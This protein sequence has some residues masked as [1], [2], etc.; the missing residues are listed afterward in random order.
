MSA[1]QSPR[2]SLPLLAAGQAQKE[3]THNEALTLLDLLFQPVI[4]SAALA[5]PPPDPQPGCIWLVAASASG[6][7]NGQSGRLAAMTE[8][9]WRFVAPF[10]GLLLWN[11]DVAQQ[12]HYHDGQWIVPNNI[13]E[14]VGGAV[15]DVEARA[16]LANI[17]ALLVKWGLA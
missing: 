10:E 4:E 3:V 7:W 14:P 8:G 2:L 9:G 17:A 13:A 16:T 5:S 15:V 12:H 11:K 6:A 1:L